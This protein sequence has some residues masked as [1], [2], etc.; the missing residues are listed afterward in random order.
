MD[1]ESDIHGEPFHIKSDIATESK[2][3]YLIFRILLL[4]EG[5][6]AKKIYIACSRT[7]H[8]IVAL[9]NFN[10]YLYNGKSEIK[11]NINNR[12]EKV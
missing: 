9:N 3:R 10:K 4:L 1:R 6:I 7:N 11:V 5:C 12:S 8:R 2:V